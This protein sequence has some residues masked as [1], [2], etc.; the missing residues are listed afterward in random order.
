MLKTRR[1]IPYHQA[2]DI[3]KQII[4]A[5]FDVHNCGYLHRDIKPAN[6]F[7]R[8]GIYKLG[9]FGFAIPMLELDKHKDYN[10]GSPVYMPP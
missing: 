7:Y 9:D 8:K 1:I 3:L 10:V 5:Y 6:V 2:V 4:L